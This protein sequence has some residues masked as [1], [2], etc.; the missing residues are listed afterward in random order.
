MKKS[1]SFASVLASGL[2][3][4]GLLTGTGLASAAPCSQCG[5]VQDIHSET[6]KG[7][8]TALG[9]VGGAV[10]GGILGNQVGKGDGNTVATIAGA[11]GGAYAGREIEK[12]QRKQTVWLTTVKMETGENRVFTSTHDPAWSQGTQVEV[13]SQGELVKRFTP[14]PKPTPRAAIQHKKQSSQKR[15]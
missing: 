8:A 1:Y 11:V 14:L 15:S 7:K 6:Q 13:N 10:V 2:L 4:L 9:T 3:G 5:V 12:R